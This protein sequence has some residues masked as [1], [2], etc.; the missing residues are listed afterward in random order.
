MQE[1]ILEI[2][3]R[4]GNTIATA[5]RSHI[6]GNPS[7]IHKV[8]HVLVFNDKGELLLQKR[9]MNKDVAP[10]RWDTSVGGHI[11]INED[12]IEAAKREMEEELGIISENIKHLYSYIHSN[13][14]ES[15]LVYTHSCMHNGPF[16]FNQDEIDEVKFWNLEDIRNM[17][18]QGILSDNFESE[19]MK[20]LSFNNQTPL[21]S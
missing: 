3:D 20:Y 13:P 7:L 15:E 18:G 4:Q 2:V 6:H 10:G 1:E 11:S 12:L 21:L 9:S 17:I 19:I 16:S 5:L 14:Y 8:V